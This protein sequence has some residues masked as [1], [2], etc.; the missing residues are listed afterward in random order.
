MCS[1]AVP[2]LPS[3]L[4]STSG[5]EEHLPLIGIDPARFVIRSVGFFIAQV[6]HRISL[7]AIPVDFKLHHYQ[8]FPVIDAPSLSLYTQISEERVARVWPVAK[9][10][11][12]PHRNCQQHK[13]GN[14]D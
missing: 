7:C 6:S 8:N 3:V 1:A 2:I 10:E 12:E 13:T 9:G 5:Q 4:N 14:P 11:C